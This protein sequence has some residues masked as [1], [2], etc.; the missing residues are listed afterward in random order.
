[1][2]SQM[3]ATTKQCE[4]K[5]NNYSVTPAPIF[6]YQGVV[7]LKLNPSYTAVV[8]NSPVKDEM[9]ETDVFQKKIVAERMDVVQV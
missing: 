6:C 7:D 5:D 9:T 4:V 3:S 1:M 2:T 8:A